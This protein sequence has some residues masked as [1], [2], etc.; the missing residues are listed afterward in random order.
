MKMMDLNLEFLQYPDTLSATVVS[1]GQTA[2]SDQSLTQQ[3]AVA[4]ACMTASLHRYRGSWM[5]LRNL[6]PSQVLGRNIGVMV[7]FVWENRKILV[8]MSI[9][10]FS[11][12]YGKSLRKIF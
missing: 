12:M 11:K 10:L 7:L 8:R 2:Q 3:P 6:S 4:A 5:P 1:I 9:S